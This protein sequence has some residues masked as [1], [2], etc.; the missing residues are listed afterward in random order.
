MKIIK[1]ALIIF[2][3]FTFFSCTSQKAEWQGSIEVVDG[4]TIVKNP[5][6]PIYGEDVLSLEEEITIGAK[7]GDE[8]VAFQ[9][10]S[11]M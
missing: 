8:N 5:K 6:E 9:R 11:D 2:F 10:N 4:V 3:I 1:V 7:E